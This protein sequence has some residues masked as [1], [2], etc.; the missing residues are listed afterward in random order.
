M[1]TDSHLPYELY[2]QI[3]DTALEGWKNGGLRDYLPS[4]RQDSRTGPNLRF[5]ATCCLVSREWSDFARKRLYA[6]LV[7]SAC[8]AADAVIPCEPP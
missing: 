4:K 1:S 5:L 2:E 3:I 8:S 7:I 6:G